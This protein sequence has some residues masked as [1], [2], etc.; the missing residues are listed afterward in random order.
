VIIAVDAT[1]LLMPDVSGIE[2]R[3][4]HIVT[5][6]ATMGLPDEIL[7]FGP[8]G[9]A[10]DPHWDDTFV[11][12]LPA[13]FQPVLVGGFQATAARYLGAPMIHTITRAFRHSRADV[14]HSFGALVPRT[15]T[16]PVVPTIHDL[17]VELDPTVRR[18]SGSTRQRN[19]IRTSAAVA[20][21]IIAV[22]HQTK[23]DISSLYGIAAERIDV[24]YNGINPAYNPAPDLPLRAALHQRYRIKEPFVLAVG[25][26]IPRRNYGR[27]LTA[28]ELAWRSNPAIK[29]LLAGRNAWP[30]TDIYKRAQAEGVLERIIW[31][32]APTDLELAALYR[33]ALLTC[34]ASSFEGFGLSVLEGLACGSPVACSDMRSLREV[35]GDAAVYFVHDDPESM[36]QTIAGLL[37]DGEYRRQLRYRGLLRAR[38]FTWANAAEN[39]LAVLRQ[40]AG[41]K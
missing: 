36:G 28:M 24:V 38:Q 32:Q 10:G 13:N 19:L 25:S 18:Q 34:C 27:M 29:L 35:A 21:R 17:S 16:C 9:A 5:H 1:P 39:V 4:Q 31:V 8:K 14:F 6:W 2:Q 23:S 7:L 15:M 3:A 11:R 33:D 40:T 20:R 30:A 12:H 37:D 22:S 26:E 41:K